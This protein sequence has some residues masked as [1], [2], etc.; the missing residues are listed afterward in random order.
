MAKSQTPQ[1]PSHKVGAG[2]QRSRHTGHPLLKNDDQVNAFLSAQAK[3]QA[4]E[5]LIIE[6]IE[7]WKDCLNRLATTP[8]G[9]HF[10]RMMIK[11]CDLFTPVARRDTVKAVEDKQRQDFYLRHC[12]PYID[13]TFRK[14]I[15]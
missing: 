7:E 1:S 5:E 3:R 9:Q 6:K 8:D 15:E 13:P 11:A 12:R 10:F 2:E 4:Q 14:D